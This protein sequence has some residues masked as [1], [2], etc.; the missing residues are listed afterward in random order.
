[1]DFAAPQAVLDALQARVAHGVFG[2]TVPTDAYYEAIAGWFARRHGWALRTEWL[3][4]SPGVVTSLVVSVLAF[5]E[6]GD[7]V[8]IQPPVYPPFRDVVR[9]NGRMVVENPLILRGGRYEMDLDHLEAQLR[10]GVKLVFLCSPHN[11]VG[12]VWTADELRRFGELCAKHGVIVVADE[13]HCDLV[14]PGHRHVPLA[15]LDEAFADIT[16]TCNA[17]TK[18][19]NI[20]G[21]HVSTAVIPNEALRR[22][23]AATLGNLAMTS[24]HT[25]SAVAL[26]AAYRHGDAW[27]DR[28]LR[29]LDEN[30][31]RVCAAFA[32]EFPIRAL[33]PEG[34][35]LVWLDCRDLGLDDDALARFLCQEAKVGLNAGASFGTGGE[36]FM[37]MNIAC[38]RATLEEGILR[39]ERAVAARDKGS[40]QRRA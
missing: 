23:F 36:G 1:M 37:R 8:L 20:P 35:Y 13:I 16:V 24:L 10:D 18:T 26:E 15:S 21:L 27:L 34:T 40:G 28:L 33:R 12:R 25:L 17:P 14:Y 6:P 32:G 39:I 2:Y 4:Y 22:R 5:T 7:K 38:P 30:L 3:V 31:R 29:Y 19:F 9:R 11:P